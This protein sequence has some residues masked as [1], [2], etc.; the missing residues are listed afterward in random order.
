M[1]I[2][3]DI[4]TAT[5]RRTG[6]GLT[7]YQLAARLP[8]VAPAAEFLYLF[9]SLRQPVP[10]FVFFRRRRVK[11]VRRRMAGPLLLLAWEHLCFPSADMLGR[12]ADLYH[13]AGMFVPPRHRIPVVTTIHDLF[14]LDRPDLADRSPWGDAYLARTLGKRLQASTAIICP[15]HITAAQVRR[16]FGHMVSGLEARLSV[17]PWGVGPRWFLPPFSDDKTVLSR[18]G[19][20]GPYI[21]S[22]V[23]S[24]IRKNVSEL[25][26]AFPIVAEDSHFDGQLVCV[27]IRADEVSR[28]LG[29]ATSRCL[30]LPY[31]GQRELGVLMRNA[32]LFVSSSYMEGFRLPVLEAMAAGVPVVTTPQVG[33][34]EFT[35]PN[36]AAVTSDATA[37]ALAHF[38]G[39]VLSDSVLQ[40]ALVRHGRQAAASLTWRRT[41]R[42]TLGVYEKAIKSQPG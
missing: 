28:L 21:L 14:F 32:A 15:S 29:P 22:I 17:I 7:T 4:S 20:N 31:V 2:A 42:E 40:R 39:Q 35:G 38:M 26:K 25:L 16:H 3:L 11:I 18:L 12:G 34:L 5:P 41:T 37:E 6:V 1:R 27:G 33:V 9:H 36:S 8:F 10:R 24:S 23:G 13:A 30:C 19:I